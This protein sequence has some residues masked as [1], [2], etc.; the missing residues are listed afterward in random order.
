MMLSVLLAETIRSHPGPEWAAEVAEAFTGMEPLPWLGASE[1]AEALRRIGVRKALRSL[2]RLVE[3]LRLQPG[4]RVVLLMD[5]RGNYWPPDAVPPGP[6]AARLTIRRGSRIE[7]LVEPAGRNRAHSVPV[8]PRHS[9]DLYGIKEEKSGGSAA[10]GRG[11]SDEG[12]KGHAV[13]RD[14]C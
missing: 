7:F 12:G 5:I 6:P 1:A 10:A 2:Y 8:P 13:S 3:K 11:K 14:L 9:R 4:V